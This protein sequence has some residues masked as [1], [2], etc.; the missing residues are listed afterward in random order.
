MKQVN[1][2]FLEE[3]VKI[4]LKEQQKEDKWG[5]TGVEMAA[6]AV[7]GLPFGSP[8]SYIQLKN[9][10][11]DIGM[12]GIGADAAYKKALDELG[13]IE[14]AGARAPFSQLMLRFY[15]T[16]PLTGNEDR[17]FD[18]SNLNLA[19]NEELAAELVDVKN[20]G[21]KKI[22]PIL[23]SKKLAGGESKVAKVEQ[24]LRIMAHRNALSSLDESLEDIAESYG[25]VESDLSYFLRNPSVIMPWGSGM[26]MTPVTL[27]KEPPALESAGMYTEFAKD[28]IKAGP[29][30][31]SDS[32]ERFIM[33][34]FNGLEDANF[35][36]AMVRLQVRSNL[37]KVAKAHM[38][39]TAAS[40]S[41]MEAIMSTADIV[42]STVTTVAFLAGAAAA[43]LT[44]GASAAAGAGSKIAAVTGIK[45]LRSFVGKSALKHANSG[46]VKSAVKLAN[47]Q[48][49]AGKT[50]KFLD[51]TKAQ[52]SPLLLLAGEMIG[53]GFL[54][55]YHDL[56][57]N[58][59][60]F[61]SKY[62]D[63]TEEER[64]K[65]FES[66]IKPAYARLATSHTEMMKTAGFDPKYLATRVS[67]I[68][69][70]RQM[71]ASYDKKQILTLQN[72]IKQTT[73]NLTQLGAMFS[74][75]NEKLEKTKEIQAKIEDSNRK[76][77]EIMNS[78]TPKLPIAA[79]FQQGAVAPTS[80]EPE[81]EAPDAPEVPASSS[82]VIFVGDSIA[83]GMAGQMQGSDKVAEV[84]KTSQYILNQ[85][86][87]RFGAGEAINEGKQGKTA[88]ISVGTNDA[89]NA[90]AGGNYTA[91]KTLGNIKEIVKLLKQNG[92]QDV[93]VMPLFQDGKP[94]RTKLNKYDFDQEKHKKFVDA[95]NSGL[96]SS[97]LS[98]FDNN[99][100]LA[101]D[102]IH[103]KNYKNLLN[104]A[105]SGGA[106]AAAK[107]TV[108]KPSGTPVKKA[109]VSGKAAEYWP[110]VK[111]LSKEQGMD[112]ALIMG[113]IFAESGFNRKAVSHVGAEGLMQLMPSVQ[114]QFGVTDVY[115]PEQNI[116]AGIRTLKTIR[117]KYIPFEMK[118]AK[119]KIS[120]DTL[121]DE[122][123]TRLGLYGFNWGA[124]GIV[125]KLNMNKYDNIDDFLARVNAWYL[126]KHGYDYADKIFKYA[127]ARGASFSA[128][129]AIAAAA[130]K[131]TTT[132]TQKAPAEKEEK[133]FETNTENIEAQIKSIEEA[134]S[135]GQ[136]LGAFSDLFGMSLG[137][138]YLNTADIR[139]AAG[140][141]EK[142]DL[143][144]FVDQR[145]K[146]LKAKHS[147]NY[148]KWKSAYQKDI[149][150]AGGD[151]DLLQQAERKM[152]WFHRPIFYV[153]LA[154]ND[155]RKFFGSAPRISFGFEPNSNRISAS[156]RGRDTFYK[157]DT[158]GNASYQRFLGELALLR[159]AT[160]AVVQKINS[161][162]QAADQQDS[163]I[164]EKFKRY[165]LPMNNI[166]SSVSE[167][168]SDRGTE[169]S[170]KAY[171]ITI[172]D[173]ALRT[174]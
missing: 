56:E 159:K 170:R 145:I 34:H 168:L 58:N 102:G 98:T 37:P 75:T 20:Y 115:D 5:D 172:L 47:A 10:L 76:A 112:P 147:N 137:S 25:F 144:D 117:N 24:F 15:K 127:N 126:S 163:E 101:S 119:T 77:E 42:L 49:K 50:L 64:I 105:L 150:A 61:I 57:R 149:K 82:D 60:N 33:F 87:K 118:R 171:L 36:K 89:F 96:A 9:Y 162:Q 1:R 122:Q 158:A 30:K 103:P 107:T 99:V 43:P 134:E 136:L 110:L 124:R 66:E 44:G 157:E 155:V 2:N 141:M 32:L 160:S 146:Y 52:L 7:L 69:S 169:A 111:R 16:M 88:I 54:D 165:I 39:Y 8:S 135:L 71:Y 121:S 26:K 17:S 83:V 128:L 23:K 73:E 93:K 4:A 142:Q 94:G 19:P 38:A 22:L 138:V 45:A 62:A 80:P 72:N 12:Y 21:Y 59:K 139:R 97:G 167:S 166:V 27:F 152:A 18:P 70:V 129:P 125:S 164:I 91:E 63:K 29:S 79:A 28:I 55:W 151:R 86:R 109:K 13:K 81:D 123:K 68:D 95:V 132:A 148:S 143:S 154:A 3:Q 14:K 116:R 6:D 100:A 161:L 67:D 40:Q 48:G 51:S 35:R 104:K 113:V 133:K 74:Q 173:L 153:T 108:T 85:L 92:Y 53:K 31:L 131:K 65:F 130:P 78:S 174:T 140:Y 11:S 90:G 156:Y 114:K 41:G 46:L 84:G 106:P 120:Y